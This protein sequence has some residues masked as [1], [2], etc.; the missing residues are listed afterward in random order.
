MADQ[1]RSILA[2]IEAGGQDVPRIRLEGPP[3][4]AEPVEQLE[5]TERRAPRTVHEQNW[6]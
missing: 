3:P 5:K 4:A 2:R 6:R 1:E